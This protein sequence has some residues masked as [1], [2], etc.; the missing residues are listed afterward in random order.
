[1]EVVKFGGTSVGTAERMRAVAELINDGQQKLVVLSAMS[2]TTNLLVDFSSR[3]AKDDK[4]A[5]RKIYD[6]LVLRYADVTKE[7]IVDKTLYEST[8]RQID[9][10]LDQLLDSIDAQFDEHLAKKILSFGEL[11]S[12]C[13]FSN[14]LHQEDINVQYLS[15]LDF[16]RVDKD[17]EPDMYYIQENLNRIVKSL[18]GTQVFVTQGFICR[19]VHGS[20]DNL[21]RGGSDYSASLMGAALE[22]DEIQ[23]LDGH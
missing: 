14:Y 5:A 2:G 15:A 4:V 11:L 17:G 3:L 23:I 8:S 18:K 20:I 10:Y 6:D 19:D 7:L 1:M 22:V 12:T 9:Q 21:D 16:M 13:L